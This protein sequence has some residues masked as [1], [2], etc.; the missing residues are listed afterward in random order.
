MGYRDSFEYELHH[1]DIGKQ[2]LD[3]YDILEEIYQSENSRIF[4]LAAEK[5][6][7][8]LLLKVITKHSEFEFSIDRAIKL[9]HKGISKIFDY[10]ESERF[11]YIIKEYVDG[12]DLETYVKEHGRLDESIVKE[13]TMMLT[14]ILDYLHN[15]NGSS[16]IF[17]DLK[18]SNI[19]VTADGSV[20]L[21]DIV[22]LREINESKDTDTFYVGSRG[23]SAPEQFGYMQSKPTSDVYSLGAT[24]YFLMTGEHPK[25]SMDFIELDRLSPKYARVVR[26]AMEFN[27]KDR[28]STVRDMA[29]DLTSNKRL[30]KV[31]SFIM[32]LTA[33]IIIS[34]A[35]LKTVDWSGTNGESDD[36]TVGDT[37]L[38]DEPSEDELSE[39][40]LS[41]EVLVD[42]AA[43]S[44]DITIDPNQFDPA[45][46]GTEAD[47][48]LSE[49]QE[50]SQ[51]YHFD[52]LDDRVLKVY[53]RRDDMSEDLKDFKY[54]HVFPDG[55]PVGEFEAKREIYNLVNDPKGLEVYLPI[56]YEVD[57]SKADNALILLF[58]D[59]YRPIG[60]LFYN[61]IP[62]EEE[63]SA[64][65]EILGTVEMG[66]GI[67]V[68]YYRDFAKLHI[69]ASLVPEFSKFS[70]STVDVSI[71]NE[72]R[73]ES[74]RQFA[75][76]ERRAFGYY[77][78]PFTFNWGGQDEFM[79]YDY[80]LFLQNDDYEIVGEYFLYHI[81]NDMTD[82]NTVLE[83][84]EE[85]IIKEETAVV[86]SESESIFTSERDLTQE[87]IE[88]PCEIQIIDGISV[89]CEGNQAIFFFDEEFLPFFDGYSVISSGSLKETNNKANVKE[90]VLTEVKVLEYF[91]QPWNGGVSEGSTFFNYDWC[92][93][94]FEGHIL[95]GEY[96]IYN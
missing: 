19:I 28:Y 50:L 4:K 27:P 12:Q 41:E 86:R 5:D 88:I 2:L 25:V 83:S 37:V 42:E 16:I 70:M 75:E 34:A 15:Y 73:K 32:G 30:A 76:T 58:A 3:K 53:L 89:S 46:Y 22:T 54:I 65:I 72:S 44:A 8:I 82:N 67:K 49:L 66:E 24:I 94:L 91:G 17:R 21:I 29:Q 68:D 64:R 45:I 60:Y 74:H 79:D 77:G 35:L 90:W 39:D 63:V 13:I 14:D 7:E 31:I 57:L 38:T 59:D 43:D 84:S 11:L 93:Y 6:G 9:D 87:S 61:N 51:G 10:M 18:P 85:P 71:Q 33:I 23:Y 47:V 69:D 55:R 96:Y 52:Y 81:E 92:I 40:E 20:K 36:T 48:D 78:D 26:R 62:F 95:V 56:G 1:T 80:A